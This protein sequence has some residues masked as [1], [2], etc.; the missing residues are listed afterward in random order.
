MIDAKVVVG[1]LATVGLAA[2]IF[3]GNQ[4]MSINRELGALGAKT[5]GI[6][7][8]LT[9][10][11]DKLDQLIIKAD[12]SA[13]TLDG[14]SSS[15]ASASLSQTGKFLSGWTAVTNEDDIVKAISGS[16]D[17]NF[18]IFKPTTVTPK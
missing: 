9:R 3:F 15:L 13:A 18:V 1:G 2:I 12:A 8:R 11:E 5:D 17:P 6:D 4:L 16:G 10:M 7:A 14:V